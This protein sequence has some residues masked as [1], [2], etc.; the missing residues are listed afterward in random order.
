MR[1]AHHA[2]GVHHDNYADLPAF[3]MLF[4]TW[5]NPAGYEH[6]TGFRPGA[7]SRVLDML[8][9]RDV[10]RPTAKEA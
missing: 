6:D 2:S 3:D 4:G 8:R 10:S 7:S 5:R 1:T 9:L